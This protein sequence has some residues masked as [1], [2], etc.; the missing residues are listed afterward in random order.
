MNYGETD[1]RLKGFD[2]DRENEIE[3]HDEWLAQRAA[4]LE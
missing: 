3:E 1:Y 2:N 4:E